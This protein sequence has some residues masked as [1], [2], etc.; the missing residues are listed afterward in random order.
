MVL[1]FIIQFSVRRKSDTVGL[2][3]WRYRQSFRCSYV[4]QTVVSTLSPLFVNACTMFL[5]LSQFIII[6]F[7]VV[8]VFQLPSKE[9]NFFTILNIL[10]YTLASFHVER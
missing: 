10:R 7:R 9:N 2:T 8:S 1:V 3:V 4:D 5:L 6:L